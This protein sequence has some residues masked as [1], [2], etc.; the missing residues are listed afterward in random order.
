MDKTKKF[1]EKAA[2]KHGDCYDYSVSVYT[3]SHEYIDILCPKHGIFTQKAYS[4]ISGKGCAECAR[5][6]IAKMKTNSPDVFITRAKEKHGD[7]YD[8][9]KVVYE[10]TNKKVII[11][12][13]DHGDF[14]V[15]PKN[16][17][18]NGSGC[19]ECALISRSEKQKGRKRP[20]IGGVKSKDTEW[21]VEKCK[22]I[23]NNRYEYNNTIYV[24]AKS[25][26]KVTCVEHGD[27]ELLA[28]AHMQGQGCAK[29]AYGDRVMTIDEFI[30][31]GNEV[32]NNKYDYSKTVYGSS[33]KDMVK[34]ICVKHGEF[35]QNAGS[36][37]A[38]HGCKKCVAHIS[39]GEA[40]LY[41]FICSLTDE[42]VKQTDRRTIK[43]LELDVYIP[44]M[45]LAIEYNGL[46]WHCDRVDGFT[47]N[48]HVDKFKRC[49]EQG[50][51]L[52]SIFDDEWNDKKDIVKNTIKHFF[53]KSEKG[54]FARKLSI[55]EIPWQEAKQFLEKYH[56]LGSGEATK[57]RIGAFDGAGNMVAVMTFG[58]SSIERSD[59]NDIEMKRFVTDSRNHPGL[60]SKMF[61]WAIKQYGFE[62]V[63]AFVDRRWFTGSFKSIAG[64]KPVGITKPTVYWTDGK[65][66]YKRRFVNKQY[67]SKMNE[68]QNSDMSKREMLRQLGFYKTWD[69]GKIK[70]EWIKSP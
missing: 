13:R 10:N 40:E 19:P 29:C 59:V 69:C 58:K 51:R 57:H 39:N 70:L 27:F 53:N 17:V 28:S 2:K 11:V 23:H 18:S 31:K 34:I 21:F 1:I 41:E 62:R 64:F 7:R 48:T 63:I 68:F 45:K 35:Y 47:M 43:P 54:I 12:C 52:L 66:R 20:G 42:E 37:L 49:E 8:Y 6:S 46:Y 25:T 33:Q 24:N 9:S 5:E 14:L 60:G 61:S 50:I 44:T 30:A 65:K 15:T 4:H 55:K 36:H 16:H 38:G 67:L 22:G 3:G 56:L 32:H 26:V